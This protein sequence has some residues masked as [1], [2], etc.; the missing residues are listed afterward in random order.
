MNFLEAIA[1][2]LLILILIVIVNNILLHGR[3]LAN[4]LKET[5]NILKE[6]LIIIILDHQMMSTK[7]Q[8]QNPIPTMIVKILN[9]KK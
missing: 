5:L 7:N 3:D 9:L 2:F 6:T 8:K 4:I 1:I